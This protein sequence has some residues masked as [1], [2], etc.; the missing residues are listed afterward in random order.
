MAL[1][2]RCAAMTLRRQALILTVLPLAYTMCA[3]QHI[4]RLG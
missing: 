4:A 3:D 2:G 1:Q